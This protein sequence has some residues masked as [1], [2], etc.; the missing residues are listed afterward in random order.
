MMAASALVVITPAARASRTFC[1][2]RAGLAFEMRMARRRRMELA[3]RR[4]FAF[5]PAT[6]PP[7]YTRLVG[8]PYIRSAA[9]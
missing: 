9:P 6:V 4:H 7:P 8:L 3:K 5:T 1:S 2:A